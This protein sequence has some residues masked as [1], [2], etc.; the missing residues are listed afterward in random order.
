MALVEGTDGV[1]GRSYRP[2][3]PFGP[4]SKERPVPTTASVP[5]EGDVVVTAP[6]PV[7]CDAAM[8]SAARKLYVRDLE[9]SGDVAMVLMS[10][11]GARA[12]WLR[13]EDQQLGSSVGEPQ[14]NIWGPCRACRSPLYLK[15]HR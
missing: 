8:G 7:N 5:N 9:A 6:V 12:N 10:P 13:S 15:T 2:L 3:A 11:T 1:G 4:Q 14:G